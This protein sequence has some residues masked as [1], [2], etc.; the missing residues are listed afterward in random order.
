MQGKHRYDNR[1]L[2]VIDEGMEDAACRAIANAKA[3]TGLIAGVDEVRVPPPLTEEETRR[4][5][6]NLDH[7]VVGV[8]ER[9]EETKAV[10][11][12]WFPWLDFSVDSHRR[13]MH[14]YSGKETARDLRPEI[15]DVLQSVSQCDLKLYARAV[16]LF[17]Q[18][19]Q[20]VSASFGGMRL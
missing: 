1:T 12:Y 10:M 18:Q 9:W 17:E 20:V 6:G 19:L 16:D 14:I 11:E 15:R 8:L 13:K 7:C 4:A 3:T 5:L 2:V